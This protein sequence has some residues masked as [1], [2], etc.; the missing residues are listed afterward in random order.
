MRHSLIAISLLAAF[1]LSAAGCADRNQ[2]GSSP[3]VGAGGSMDQSNTKRGNS[4]AQGQDNPAGSPGTAGGGAGTAGGPASSSTGA[5]GGAATG[6]TSGSV[7]AGGG[8]AGGA[9]GGTGR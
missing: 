9:S 4:A 5:A 7:G 8:T 6:D 1:G 3:Q 2:N